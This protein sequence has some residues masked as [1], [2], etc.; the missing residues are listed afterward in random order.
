MSVGNNFTSDTV[1]QQI[2]GMSV[3]L[4][5][6]CQDIV[7]LST[8]ING[9]GTGL[10]ML[11]AIGYDSDDAATAQGAIS[12]LNTVAEVYFGD[13]TQTPAFN[14]DQELSQYWAGQ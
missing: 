3:R 6:L 8:N 9:Q 4:R 13:A 10:A 14:F 5:D 12:Y 11:E 1:N 2:T 7:N